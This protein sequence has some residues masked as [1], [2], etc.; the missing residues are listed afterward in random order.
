[1]V[2]PTLIWFTRDLR[3]ADHPALDAAARMGAPVVA[4]FVLDDVSAG[5]WG[6]G[7]ASRWFLAGALEALASAVAARGGRLVLRR[8]RADEIVAEVAS[9]VRARAVFWSRLYDP[10]G[11]QIEQRL[12]K[13]LGD[14]GIAAQSLPGTLLFEPT[15]IV[16]A[17]GEPYRVF[18]PFS[19]AWLAQEPPQAPLPVPSELV[20]CDPGLESETIASLALRP[21]KPDWAVGMRAVWEPSEQG[22]EKLLARFLDGPIWRYRYERDFPARCG[23]SRLSP[24]LAHGTISPRRVYWAARARAEAEGRGFEA[25]WPF[26]RQLVWREFAWSNLYHFPQLPDEPLRAEFAHFPWSVDTKALRAWQKGRTGYPIVDAGMRELWTTGWMHN[27]VRMIVGSFLT[28]DLRIPWQEGER[29]FW[30][31][32]V[33]ADLANNAMGWQWVAGCG[34]DAAPYFRIFNP[35]LQ[36]KKFDPDGDYVRRWVPELARLP[37]AWIHEPWRAPPLVLEEAGVRLGETYPLPIVDHEQARKAAL[38]AFAALRNG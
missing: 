13:R 10:W 11:R 2:S 21:T 31:T 19:R 30:D 6:Y 16:Q 3:L 28:K 15:Q 24:H 35:I 38:A 12:R 27:R 20:F 8:G 18:T 23:V 36:A 33:D 25:V 14:F 34:I 7:S 17:D 1:M 32:L 9:R 26:I 29:W 37:S 5:C 22:A 4:L